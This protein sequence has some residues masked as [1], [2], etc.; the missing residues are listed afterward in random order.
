V[1]RAVLALAVGLAAC[2]GTATGGEAVDSAF[3]LGD[4]VGLIGV[5]ADETSWLVD[6]PGGAGPTDGVIGLVSTERGIETLGTA[7]LVDGVVW[8]QVR[9]DEHSGWLPRAGLAVLGEA[10]DV[11]H[12]Y[13][14]VRAPTIAGLALEIAS[15]IEASRLVLVDESAGGGVVYDVLGLGDDSV[16]GF[17]VE[18]TAIGG[19]G[20]YGPALVMRTPLCSLGIGE[21]GRCL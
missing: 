21:D 7:R 17:R 15:E 18:V 10:E 2:G 19:S 16:A 4:L 13:R 20:G 14:G 1:T 5:A 9:L 8:E 3:Q 12:L 11:T 6:H